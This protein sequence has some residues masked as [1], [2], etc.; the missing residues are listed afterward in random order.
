MRDIENARELLHKLFECQ[1]TLVY[2]M[3]TMKDTHMDDLIYVFEHDQEELYKDD[4]L[5]KE[6]IAQCTKNLSK[7]L[8]K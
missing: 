7:P 5:I 1:V 6:G 4:K 8:E 3:A 2:T